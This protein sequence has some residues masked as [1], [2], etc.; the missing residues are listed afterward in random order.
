M[1]TGL[2]VTSARII[3]Q[4]PPGKEHTAGWQI[5][6]DLEVAAIGLPL[7]IEL[8]VTAYCWFPRLSAQTMR[9]VPFAKPRALGCVWSLRS[10]GYL[11]FTAAV[12]PAAS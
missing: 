2:V 6:V 3:L 8:P 7:G 5:G 11:D 12:A 1:K 4:G 10:D 9:K